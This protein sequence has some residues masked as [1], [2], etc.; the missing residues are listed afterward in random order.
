MSAGL[1][2]VFA[3]EQDDL[4]FSTLSHNLIAGHKF[5]G[6]TFERAPTASTFRGGAGGEAFVVC[7]RMVPAAPG[8]TVGAP[9]PRWPWHKSAMLRL[10]GGFG[11][12][13]CRLWVERNWALS[14]RHRW[15]FADNAWWARADSN[16]VFS[17]W[18]SYTPV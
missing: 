13:K 7:E 15:S 3:V 4:A 6:G 5:S 18:L 11:N 10:T 14:E 2:G 17:T 12:A 1:N 16:R 9:V 8:A